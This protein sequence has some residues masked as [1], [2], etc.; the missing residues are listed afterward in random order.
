MFRQ[1]SNIDMADRIEA[2]VERFA[3]GFRD[4]ILA[5]HDDPRRIYGEII[6]PRHTLVR[7]ITG[8]LQN[9]FC[10]SLRAPRFRL[11]R[12]SL[13]VAWPFYLFPCINASRRRVSTEMLRATMRPV[14][15]PLAIRYNRGG[16]K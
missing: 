12:F 7:D 3:P 13:P 9:I 6:N 2:Q 14:A 1:N 15:R 11:N 4:C 10:R 16:R 8:G 5:R